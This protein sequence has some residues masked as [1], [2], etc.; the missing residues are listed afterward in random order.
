MLPDSAP[1]ESPVRVTGISLGAGATL[2]FEVSGSVNY[3]EESPATDSPDGGSCFGGTPRA[4]GIAAINAPVNALVGVFLDDRTRPS[5]LAPATLIDCSP[6]GVTPFGINFSSAS[7]EVKEVFI[8][9]GLDRDG[10][11]LTLALRLTAA[12][13]GKRI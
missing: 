11:G 6:D 1:A 8:G 2:I 4:N 5:S 10:A 13:L 3:T 12:R 9:G 7:P